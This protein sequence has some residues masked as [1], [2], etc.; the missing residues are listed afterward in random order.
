[1]GT[2]AK[3]LWAIT[4]KGMRSLWPS[5]GQQWT[6]YAL[7]QALNLFLGGT[8]RAQHIR[9]GEEGGYTRPRTPSLG[10]ISDMSLADNVFSNAEPQYRRPGIRMVEGMIS[11]CGFPP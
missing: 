8:R 10:Y 4:W 2:K 3:P 7:P 6:N 11:G 9:P 1:M 5:G